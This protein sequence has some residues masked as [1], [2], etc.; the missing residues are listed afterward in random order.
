MAMTQLVSDEPSASA[1]TQRSTQCTIFPLWEF[2][3]PQLRISRLVHTFTL[4]HPHFHPQEFMLLKLNQT[5]M[6]KYMT[7]VVALINRNA[8]DMVHEVRGQGA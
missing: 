6:T 3:S 7:Q 1:P 8:G 2:M 4:T 5:R